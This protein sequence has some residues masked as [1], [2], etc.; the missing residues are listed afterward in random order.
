MIP[1]LFHFIWVG[2]DGKR[3]DNCIRTW[4][5]RHPGWEFRLWGNDEL[6]GGS[7]DAGSR[8]SHHRAT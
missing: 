4:I 5:D 3:P 7:G 6:E 8:S 1:K 2:D